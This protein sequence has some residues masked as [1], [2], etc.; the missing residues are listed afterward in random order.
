M[1]QVKRKVHKYEEEDHGTW[2][3]GYLLCMD[4][5]NMNSDR[6]YKSSP[7]WDEVTCKHCRKKGGL[8]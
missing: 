3:Y 2:R 7:I 5:E 8:P 6:K 4:P 1:R